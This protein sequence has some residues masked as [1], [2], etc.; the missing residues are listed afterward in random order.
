MFFG[1]PPVGMSD[2]ALKADIYLMPT[3]TLSQLSSA[4]A[5]GSPTLQDINDQFA[6][7]TKKFAIYLF[8]E[9]LQ[10]DF[11]ATEDYVVAQD[12]ADPGW[13]TAERAGIHAN[14]SQI[15]NSQK[16]TKTASN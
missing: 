12:S 5:R 2:A 3:V 13:E 4:L 9:Q 10:S 11:G 7:L 8:W 1:T 14:H 16:H 15:A 6:H